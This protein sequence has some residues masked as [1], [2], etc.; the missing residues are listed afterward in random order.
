MQLFYRKLGKGMPFIILHGLYGSSDNWISVARELSVNLEVWLIDLRN[1][2]RSPHHKDH[3]YE[4]MVD[5]LYEFVNEHKLKKFVL[6][7]HSMGGK[8]AMHFADSHPELL[9]HLIIIDIAPKSYLFS[10][11]IQSDTLNHKQIME[12]MLAM[13]FSGITNREEIDLHLTKLV[14]NDKIRHFLMKNIK[15]KQDMSFDWSLNIEALYLNLNNILC[16]L[17]VNSKKSLEKL[18]VLFVKGSDSEYINKLDLEDIN[19]IFPMAKLEIIKDA[20]HWLHIEKPDLLIKTIKEFI[21]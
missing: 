12:G 13:D 5:D 17:K 16:E 20:G 1:H 14:P 15:R 10:I 6:L 4:I 21:F 9:S 7:G 19:T 18:P 8:L 11:D 3:T 2:G